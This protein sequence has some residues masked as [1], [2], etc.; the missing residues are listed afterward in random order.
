MFYLIL[1]HIFLFS[2]SPDVAN[3]ILL[4][5]NDRKAYIKDQKRF[6]HNSEGRWLLFK[7]Y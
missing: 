7:G 6:G 5:V 3:L 1:F 4:M 2:V